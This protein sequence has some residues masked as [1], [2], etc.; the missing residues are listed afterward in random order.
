MHL[1][2][3]SA[4]LYFLRKNNRLYL[5][6]KRRKRFDKFL[7]YSKFECLKFSVLRKFNFQAKKLSHN[8]EILRRDTK[9]LRRGKSLDIKYN[10]TLK[11][12]N[13]SKN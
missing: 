8:K 9:I 7:S 11:G 10:Y 2:G 13:I 5:R 6:K 12:L 3:F 4:L 1:T